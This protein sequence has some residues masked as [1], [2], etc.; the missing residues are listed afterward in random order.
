MDC[1]KLDLVP[2]GR[3]FSLHCQVCVSTVEY[4]WVIMHVS[5]CSP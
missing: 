3:S 1:H 2:A 5:S 4:S